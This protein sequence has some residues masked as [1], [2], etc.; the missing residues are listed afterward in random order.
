MKSKA[1][2]KGIQNNF[3][4]NLLLGQLEPW[5][6]GKGWASGGKGKGKGSKGKG[7]GKGYSDG[8]GKG[9]GKN[10]HLKD[11]DVPPVPGQK[12]CRCCGKDGHLKSECRHKHQ[13]CNNCLKEGRLEVV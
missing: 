10:H 7:K 11:D 1:W 5:G 13:K 9:K 3:L 8:K 12:W 4:A 6:N 2:G